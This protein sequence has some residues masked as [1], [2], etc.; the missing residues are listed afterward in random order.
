M[1]E[2]SVRSRRRVIRLLCL[3]A[4][5]LAVILLAGGLGR[6]NAAGARGRSNDQRLAYL[7]SLGW[8]AD[9]TPQEEKEVLLPKVFPEV[10]QNYNELQREAGYDLSEYAGKK[11]EMYVYRL[12]N[13]PSEAEVLCTLYVHRGRIVGGDIHST[14]FRG[15]MQPL[16]RSDE[17]N[18]NG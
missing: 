16:R 5:A 8:E 10:L 14:A 15:F 13:W 2:L 1:R 9:E 18:K 4:L 3:A 7:Q 11:L 17:M 12:K 6:R